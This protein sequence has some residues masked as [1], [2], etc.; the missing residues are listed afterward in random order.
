[1]CLFIL[2][3]LHTNAQNITAKIIDAESGEVLPYANIQI[4]DTE[5]IISNGEGYFTLP[6]KHNTDATLLTVSFLGY[7]SARVRVDELKK[8]DLT[9][10]LKPGAFSLET[11]YISSEDQ[12]QRN[13]DTIMARVK[14]NLASNYKRAD[15]PT[16]STFFFREG[17]GFK[18]MKLNAVMTKSSGYKKR[19]LKD[20]NAE[21]NAFTSRLITHPPMEFADMLCN[22]YSNSKMNK[23]EQV[24]VSKCEVVKAVKLKDKNRAVDLKE[25]QQRASEIVFKHLDSTK[26]YRVKSGLFGTRDTV[27]YA[28]SFKHKKEKETEPQ[29][30]AL[31]SAKSQV[32]GFMS[33]NS[34]SSSSFEFMHKRELYEYSYAGATQNENDEWI[35][36]IN[37]KPKKSKGKYVGTLYVS[38]KDYAVVRADYALGEGKKLGGV[39]MKFLLGVKQSENISRGTLIFKERENEPGYYLQYASREEGSYIY[40]NR[41][42]KF[43]EITDGDKDEV[44]FDLKVEA[45]M[46]D[47]EEYF[48]ISRSE[49]SEAQYE[50]A[51]EH[52]VD[53]I[54]LDSYDPNTW[55]EYT[56]IEPV[57]EM[58]RFKTI[59]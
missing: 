48:V 4:N 55:K 8:S 52:E 50:D 13:P 39:N 56:T 18:P 25:L 37:F 33:A 2:A 51:R 35:Y 10:K 21:L 16:K 30:S 58:K 31:T 42:L 1:M 49:I 12:Q 43:I 11:V 26:F 44:A 7:E 47:K 34:L 19:D 5:S 54:H 36:V 6:P 57:Q 53:Y 38:K 29:K 15:K 45:N 3:G 9:V 20:S 24:A 28:S 22:Y 59:E 23:N 32:M 46:V 27:L 17:T 41:P 40:L 14:K